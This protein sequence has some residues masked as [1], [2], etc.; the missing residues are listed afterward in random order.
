M[1]IL[2]TCAKGTP[3]LELL[4][5]L[6]VLGR[7]LSKFIVIQFFLL[8]CFIAP[9]ATYE[10]G[11]LK[12]QLRACQSNASTSRESAIDMC[13]MGCLLANPQTS[14]NP[15]GIVTKENLPVVCAVCLDI[16]SQRDNFYEKCGG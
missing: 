4:T 5:C 14:T 15:S 10:D 7:V 8:G 13:F 6:K 12:T 9:D 1:N 2:R 16:A 11:E 3:A